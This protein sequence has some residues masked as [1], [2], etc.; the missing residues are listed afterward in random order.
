MASLT[1]EEQAFF[2]SGGD[3]SKLA[4]GE[5]EPA[6]LN[7]IERDALG[8]G[9]PSPEPAPTAAPVATP[10]PVDP[11]QSLQ[12]A[13]D[14]SNAQLRQLTEQVE[15][16]KGQPKPQPTEAPAPDPTTDPLGNMLHQ[17]DKVNRTVADLK[18]SI[19]ERQTQDTQLTAFNNFRTQVVALRDE[20]TKT[21][22]DFQAAFDYVRNARTEDLRAIGMPENDIARTLFQEELGLAQRAIAASKNPAA[23][24]Y[25]MAKRHGYKATAT[26]APQSKI[27]QLK[28]GIAASP[29]ALPKTH[30]AEDITVESLREA[31]DADLNRLVTDPKA[32]DKIAGKSSLP[33]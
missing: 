26:P 5:A 28:A 23:E 29:P 18:A 6:Q 10:A 20:F 4:P 22:P 14:N 25:E 21:T 27:E 9:E 3:V 32:W 12:A 15:S 7:P 30:V 24:V 2:D 16:L 31:S 33:I 13:L 11:M 19:A 8:T 17:L 1:P